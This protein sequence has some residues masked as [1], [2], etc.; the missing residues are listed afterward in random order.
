MKTL[1][2]KGM[3]LFIHIME[4]YISRVNVLLIDKEESIQLLVWLFCSD[5][6]VCKKIKYFINVNIVTCRFFQSSA[7]LGLMDD[8]NSFS[9]ASIFHQCTHSKLIFFNQ[10]LFF[11]MDGR[12]K[13]WFIR[14]QWPQNSWYKWDNL[15]N[16]EEIGMMKYSIYFLQILSM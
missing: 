10:L 12:N 6:K 1:H 15:I 2:C 7:F 9:T 3:G 4:I 14:I 5:K 16:V 8:R 11:S 13:F